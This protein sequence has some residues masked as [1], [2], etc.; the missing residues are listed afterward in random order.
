VFPNP[1]PLRDAL[2]ASIPVLASGRRDDVAALERDWL[3]LRA[4]LLDS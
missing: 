3:G 2:E 1:T 4:R